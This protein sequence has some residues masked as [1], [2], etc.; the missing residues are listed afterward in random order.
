V[1]AAAAAGLPV[2]EMLGR[3]AET[4]EVSNDDLRALAEKR[5]R[6]VRDYFINEGKIDADRLFLTQATTE[7][8]ENKGP[9]V[10]LTLQ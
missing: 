8:K 6:A 9:R 1:E 10:Y 3:L 7:Q 2:E 5:A 4:M